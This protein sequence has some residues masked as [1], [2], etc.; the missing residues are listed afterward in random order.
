MAKRLVIAVLVVAV[1]LTAVSFGYL[2]WLA[3]MPQYSLALLVLEAHKGDGAGVDRYVDSDSVVDNFVP[4]I[5]DAAVDLY[6]RGIPESSIEKLEKVAEPLKPRIKETARVEVR[7]L[8]REKTLPFKGYPAFALATGI[9]FY[10][11]ME[12]EGGKAT[13][14][15]TTPEGDAVEI[16][17]IR[18][19]D[20]WR[21]VE[22]RDPELAR[23]VAETVGQEVLVAATAGGLER[24]AKTLKITDVDALLEK[25]DG[26]FR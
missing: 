2:K 20:R 9:S 21:I 6:G 10:G 4:Q 19:Q 14:K 23:R 26:I 5:R 18:S 16:V 22:V 7:R 3:G 13:Y 25:L 8:V 17:L 11:T 12:V 15:A 1:S 24:V